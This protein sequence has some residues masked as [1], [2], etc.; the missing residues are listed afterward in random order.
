VVV[1]AQMHKHNGSAM[2]AINIQQVQTHFT[3][4]VEQVMSSASGPRRGKGPT[5]NSLGRMKPWLGSNGYLN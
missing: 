4:L 1:S 3:A 5:A 2:R